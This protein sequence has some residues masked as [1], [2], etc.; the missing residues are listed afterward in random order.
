[1]TTTKP[2]ILSLRNLTEEERNTLFSEY[3]HQI[4]Q[5]KTIN[6]QV[7]IVWAYVDWQKVIDWF[8]DFLKNKQ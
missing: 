3:M 1:M 6:W 7:V 4:G 8:R 5:W 2:K